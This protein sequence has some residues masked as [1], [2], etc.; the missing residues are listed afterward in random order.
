MT[1][2]PSTYLA[3]KLALSR[4]ALRP[5]KSFGQ[6]FLLAEDVLR[7]IALAAT[8]GLP[9]ATIVELG[10]GTGALTQALL[11]RGA[12][13]V[14]VERDRDLLPLLGA[15]FEHEIIAGRVQLV[16]GD[17]Q[18]VDSVQL[19]GSGLKILTG[20]LPY[21]ITGS[22]IEKAVREAPA[23][24]RAVFM[25]QLEVADRMVAAPDT[26]AYG[27][28]SVF[29]QAAYA[30][31][32]LRVVP[33]ACFLP[34][35]NVTS[36]VIVLRPHAVP[37]ALETDMFRSLVKLAFGQ[38]RKTLRNAWKNAG[39]STSVASS[40]ETAGISLNARGETLSV[41]D[42]ARMATELSICVHSALSA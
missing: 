24:S 18:E 35:P 17:A 9:G 32:R 28:L 8:D 21:Q 42:F 30:V 11:K 5:K 2:P 36:A 38:R 29:V 25:V 33:P 3:P 20:N 12:K 1:E 39:D 16:E 13:V 31:T 19:A 4:A 10:A 41:E 27:A 40:A 6:N 34:P 7:D 22:L 23:W 37:R 15:Q 26:E 14:A